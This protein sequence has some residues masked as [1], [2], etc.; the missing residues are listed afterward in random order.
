[1]TR[2]HDEAVAARELVEALRQ[3]P[4]VDAETIDLSLESETGIKGALSKAI[5]L[6]DE[7]ELLVKQIVAR[8][9]SMEFRASL[10]RC[11][12]ERIEAEIEQALELLPPQALPLRLPEATLTLQ[13]TGGKVIISNDAEVPDEWCEVKTKRTPKKAEILK[14]LRAGQDVPGAS[15]ANKQRTL[16]IKR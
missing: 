6:R 4:D 12:V 13:D 3:I 15:L 16:R 1:M 7:A 11:R 14:A 5:A 2:L 9:E 8:V 10:L